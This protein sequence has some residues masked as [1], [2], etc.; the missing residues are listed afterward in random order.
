MGAGLSEGA[1][2]G[3]RPFREADRPGVIELWSRTDLTRPWNDPDRDIDRKLAHDPDGLLVGIVAGRVVSTAMAGYDGHRGWVNYLAVGPDRRGRGYGRAMM[4][5][6]IA[7]LADRGCPK[8]NVQVRRDHDDAIAF[9]R[10][11]GFGTDDVVSLG[12][13]LVDDESG[14][15]PLSPD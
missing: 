7:L 4:D 1:P 15:D 9:Y 2:L 14:G 5:A 10:A 12:R 13:R 8:V 11:L 3:I 6:A